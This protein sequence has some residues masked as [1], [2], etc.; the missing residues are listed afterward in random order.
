[1][2]VLSLAACGDSAQTGES[3]PPAP[4]SAE[5]VVGAGATFPEPLYQRWIKEF[6]PGEP[7]PVRYYGVGSGEGVTRFIAGTVDFGA[8][9]AAM[10]DRELQQVTAGTVMVPAT[11]GM[12]VLA[13]NLPQVTGPLRL[14]RDV[15]VDIFLGKLTEW[16]DPR[17]VQ[18]NPDLSLP[19]KTIQVV[20]RRDGSGTT[21]AFTNHLTEISAA[22]RQG[23]GTG[24]K[25]DFPGGAITAA[26]NTGVA[27]MI[28]I[29]EGA[30]GYV[31]Y[32]FA[33]RLDLPVVA[34]QNRAGAYVE[35]S[36]ETGSAAIDA[37]TGTMP[38]NL[39]LFLPDPEGKDSYPI[40]SMSWLLLY[41]RYTDSE[42]LAL[43]RHWVNQG[44]SSRGQQLARE[45][46]Y[47]P[48]P[49]SIVQKAMDAVAKIQ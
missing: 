23:P 6:A 19:R 2:A 12:V 9:D 3:R 35:P 33:R 16:N 1:M 15:Y 47:I 48:L 7:A 30:I 21:Y 5:T 46:G 17:I 22:W 11:A 45:L 34:L 13:Y 24:K 37:A 4:V 38:E 18:A 8:S 20:T 41:E 44:L 10:T 36:P 43:L 31:E 26:G 32:G 49:D 14:P 29:S 42:K 25:V 28:K 27:Q 39:R 40:V